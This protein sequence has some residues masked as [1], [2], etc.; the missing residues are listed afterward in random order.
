MTS[1]LHVENLRVYYHTPR[2]TVKA[3]DDVTF[4][5]EAGERFGLIGESGS[6]K[7]TIALA[8]MR[9]IRPP[10]VIES[11]SIRLDGEELIDLTPDEMRQRRLARVAMVTQGA[12]NSLNPV[13]RIRQQFADGLTS[14]DAAASKERIREWLNQLL[15]RVGLEPN[16]ADMYP[17]QLSGGMKQ[18]VCIALAMS[19]RPSLIIADEPTSALDVVVQR[20]VM[21]TLRQAQEDLNAA[22]ILIGHDMGL[23]AQFASRIG[24]MYA[25][26][27][28][29]EGP[30]RSIFRKPAHPYT[31]LLMES[32][33]S[34]EDRQV[35][36]GAAAA[37]VPPS[38][39]ERP[40]GCVFHPRCPHA[41][42]QCVTTPPVYREV[43]REQWAACHLHDAEMAALA[44]HAEKA[45]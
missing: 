42:P 43:A 20:Q 31:Q 37:S 35:P 27:L 21:Q 22:V 28:V 12:M 24:V 7:S 10:G 13:I 34:L 25:G 14:H 41:M 29:E 2:G 3:V 26:K 23:M 8:I 18:R 32:L 36:T 30:V 40:S 19:L 15:T 5:V 1:I 4:S 16:V 9:L 38:A 44:P 6:G 33:P 45:A 17:H 39:A 11:G